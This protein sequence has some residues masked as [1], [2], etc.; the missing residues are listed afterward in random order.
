M[1][2]SFNSV[3]FIYYLFIYFFKIFLFDFIYGKLEVGKSHIY[4][5]KSVTV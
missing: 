5:D 4:H 1:K 2:N 3:L